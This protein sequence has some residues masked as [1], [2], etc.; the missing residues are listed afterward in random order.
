MSAGAATVGAPWRA[1][2]RGSAALLAGEAVARAVS[3]VAVVVLARRLG[4]EGFGLVTLALTL[5]LW[6]A[7]IV[8]SGT[9]LLNVRDVARR[10]ERFRHLTEP[11]L[12]L[13]LAL[14]AAAALLLGAL[15]LVLADRSDRSTLL[16][17]ALVLPAIALNL[18]WM[19]LGVSGARAVAVGNVAAQLVLAIGVL[20]L[21]SGP[22]DVSRVPVLQALG[23][24]AYGALVLTA[25]I[26]RFGFPRPRVDL[27]AWRA[28]L[29]ESLPLLLT[30][31][32]RA[33]VYFADIVII[34][35]VLGH[36]EVGVYGAVSKAVLFAS[37]AFGLFGVSF[38]AAYSSA[39]ER[40]TQLFLRSARL[41]LGVSTALAL[42]FSAGAAFFVPLVYGD[43]YRTGVAALA[44]VAWSLPPLALAGLHGFVL[45]THGHQ[46]LLLRN[47]LIAAL[48]SVSGNLVAVPVFGI[49]GA[50]AMA[51]AAQLTV[52]LLNVRGC[53]GLGLVPP[54]SRLLLHRRAGDVA[55]AAPLG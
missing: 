8:D 32:A 24:L 48:V 31:L 6:L 40:A 16:L 9:E 11:V 14:C 37:A 22:S 35:V 29:R 50:A 38:L 45:L 44:L 2:L 49:T 27:D 10:P 23:E 42:L 43:S 5:V 36:A 46:R 19:V 18:R 21:V 34:A 51:V 20:L 53:S 15:T 25:V 47:S 12:G 54:I 3:F 33:T 28:T 17:F 1:L 4:P 41:L 30:G 7:Q 55:E 39:G 13:R 52:L 26:G